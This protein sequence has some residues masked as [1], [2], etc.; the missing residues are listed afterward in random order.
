ME[1]LYSPIHVHPENNLTS[2]STGCSG[3]SL[4]LKDLLK[5]KEGASTERMI[6]YRDR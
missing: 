1:G 2:F 5:Q 3:F 6:S 4:K